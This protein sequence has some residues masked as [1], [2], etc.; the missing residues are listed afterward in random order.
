MGTQTIQC[1]SCPTNIAE[2]YQNKNAREQKMTIY[3]PLTLQGWRQEGGEETH[4]AIE[5]HGGG[6]R[7]EKFI[8]A[9]FL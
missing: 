1:S 8:D 2:L 7:Y 9:P 6:K 3:E 5:K 4:G